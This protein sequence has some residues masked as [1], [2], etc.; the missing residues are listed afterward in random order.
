MQ[1]GQVLGLF[2]YSLFNS[3]CSK[4]SSIW[5]LSNL[6]CGPCVS[7]SLYKYKSILRLSHASPTEGS[8]L[9]SIVSLAGRRK[10]RLTCLRVLLTILV[11]HSTSSWQYFCGCSGGGGG[12]DKQQWTKLIFAWL[13]HFSALFQWR[14][15]LSSQKNKKKQNTDCRGLAAA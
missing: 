10:V 9:T 6:V 15:H 3:W 2:I 1:G 13:I 12:G 8:V 14:N 5:D 4:L 11:T 7:A